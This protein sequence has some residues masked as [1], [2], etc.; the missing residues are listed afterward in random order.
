MHVMRVLLIGM[1]IVALP[2]LAGADVIPISDV[3]ENDE[4]GLSVLNG[5]VV[6]VQ[7]VAVVGTGTLGANTDIYIQDGTGGVNV[8]QADMASPVIAVGDSVRVTGKVGR[9]TIS[10]RTALFIDTAFPSTRMVVVNS[11][12]EIPVPL[13]LTPR[14]ISESGD[15]LEGIY[16]V[17][18]GISLASGQSWVNCGNPPSDGSVVVADGDTSCWLWFDRDTDLCGPPEPLETFEIYGFVVPAI[19]TIAESGHGILPVMRSDVLSSGPGSGFVTLEPARAYTGVTTD[20]AF[21]FEADGGE[22]TQVSIRLPSGWDFLGHMSDVLLEG[23]AFDGAAIES[24]P[25]VV[26]LTGCELTQGRPGTVTLVGTTAPASAGAYSSEV[27]TADAGNDLAGIQSQPEIG[28]GAQAA[29]GTVLINEIYAYSGGYDNLDRSEF[30]E[31]YNPGDDAVDLTGWV[32]TDID[33]SGACGG[34]NLWEFPA[35]TALEA[36]G[37]VVIAKDAKFNYYAGFHSLFGEFPDFELFDPYGTDIDWPDNDAPNMI[38]V[39]PD[40]NDATVNQEIRLVGGADGSG[41]LVAGAPAYEAVLLYT[42][43][44]MAYPIDA[45]EYRDPVYLAE[46]PCAGSPELGGIDD[47]WTPGPPP[48]DTSLARNEASDDTGVSRDDFFLV[49]PTPGEQNPASDESRPVVES[50]SGASHNLALVKFSEPV[51]LYDAEAATNYVVIGDVGDSIDVVAAELSR[52]RR[53]VLLTTTSRIPGELYALEV[54]GVR[55]VAGNLMES[56]LDTLWIQIGATTTS[57]TD[58]QE[59]D[60]NGLSVRAGETV[61]AVG[62]T[63]VPAG[64]FQPQYTSMYIQEPDGAGVNVFMFGQMTEPALEGDLISTTGTIVDY[65]GSSG[66]GATTEVEANSVSVLARGFAPLPPTVMATGDVGHEDNEGLFVRTSGV[67]VSVEGFAIYIDDGSGSIQIYQNFNNLDFS[68]F[69]VGDNVSMTG[70]ILQYDQT[71]PFLSGY[72]LSPRYD[73]DMEILETSYSGSAAIE[74]VGISAGRVLDLGANE[75]IEISYNAPKASH[76]TVRIFDLKGREVVTLYD[77]IC[78]GPQQTTWD[79]R[80]DE[81]NR[82]SMGTYLCH[83]MVRDRGRGNGSSAAVPIVVGRKLD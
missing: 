75:A 28:V 39:S 5:T 78:L 24:T 64:V 82:V 54:D 59:Y 73:A 61:K 25:D 8:R 68:V 12:N 37:Y 62:L 44:T 33:D 81:G 56:P 80:D 4:E 43:L 6:T 41:T 74:I 63:T 49:A 10:Y 17:I 45:V 36:G 83:V 51:D 71:A 55:D 21:A 46:D 30:I 14:E 20:L 79:A 9:A 66:A 47:A 67:V 31:L 16:A 53:T 15:D 26:V 23:P 32:L 35:G 7:G 72:E 65:I 70:V 38:L 60:E 18:R 2:A 13:E 34:S 77:G 57:I 11:G 52:D 19:G 76:V 50:A 58:L 69:A 40:D 22:L 1:F 42:D 3:N 48:W 29:A 27:K